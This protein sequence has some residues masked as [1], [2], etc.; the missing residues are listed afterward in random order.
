MAMKDATNPDS[1]PLE[2]KVA[3][4]DAKLAEL[5]EVVRRIGEPAASELRRR[6]AALR[7]EENALKRNIHELTA[8]T[9][10]HAIRLRKIETLLQHIEREESSVAHEAA[11]LDECAPSSMTLAAEGGKKLAD[12]I[13]ESVR[14]V[15][16][17]HHPPGQS[18]FV[19]H[20]QDDLV[21]RYGLDD[22]KEN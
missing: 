14:K 21:A 8:G 6:V 2:A 4:A 15:T 9:E 13:G 20:T 1:L 7:G 10:A 18:V 22:E 16:K 19:N 5:E 11:F 3:L 12:A 17:G